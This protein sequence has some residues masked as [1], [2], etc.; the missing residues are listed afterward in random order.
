MRLRRDLREMESQKRGAETCVRWRRDARTMVDGGWSWN[1]LTWRRDATDCD[2]RHRQTAIY[3]TDEG[4][5]QGE[6]GRERVE[7]RYRSAARSL[8][9]SRAG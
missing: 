4:A 7:Q 3:A 9:F 8:S 2:K 1:F 6:T 5:E